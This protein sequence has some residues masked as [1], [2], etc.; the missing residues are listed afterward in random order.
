MGYKI[1]SSKH[2]LYKVIIYV[3]YYNDAAKKIQ[4]RKWVIARDF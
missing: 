4:Y 1:F 3:D 2:K